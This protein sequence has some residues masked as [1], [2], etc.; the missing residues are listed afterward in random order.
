MLQGGYGGLRT[1][2]AFQIGDPPYEAGKIKKLSRLHLDLSF[3]VPPDTSKTESM[4][5][6]IAGMH[7][8][9]WSVY[10][11]EYIVAEKLEAMFSRGSTNSRSKDIFDL[12]FLLPKVKNKNALRNAIKRIFERCLT[13][14]PHSFVSVAEEFDLRIMRSA[15]M[16]VEIDTKSESFEEHWM[17]FLANLRTI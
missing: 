10:P 12:N 14:I 8:V 17:H 2:F 11:I 13:P 9:S 1:N 5:S 6:C 3:E 4:K 7:P 16:S 15:W